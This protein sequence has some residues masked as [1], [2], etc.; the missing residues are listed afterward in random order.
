MKYMRRRRN[1]VFRDQTKYMVQADS[2]AADS[3]PCDHADTG[4]QPRHRVRRGHE[5]SLLKM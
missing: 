3:V 4:Y 2:V 5:I 1:N